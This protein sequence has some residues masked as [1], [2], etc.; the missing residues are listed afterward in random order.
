MPGEPAFAFAR[1]FALLYFLVA[2]AALVIVLVALWRGMRAHESI[3]RSLEGIERALASRAE[4][5]AP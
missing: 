1:L 2:F 3:A 4:P 5:P